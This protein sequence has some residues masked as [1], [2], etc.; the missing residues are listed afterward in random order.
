MVKKDSRTIDTNYLTPSQMKEVFEDWIKD[1]TKHMVDPN[2]ALYQ[3]VIIK[4]STG[5]DVINILML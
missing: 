1:Q 3:V 2:N 5:R 4:V